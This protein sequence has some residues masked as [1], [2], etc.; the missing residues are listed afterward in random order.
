MSVVTIKLRLRDKHSASLQKQARAVNFVWN[1]CNETQRKAAQSGRQWL[2]GFDLQKLT[3]GS[4]QMLGLHAHTIQRV[5]KTY[6]EARRTRRKP[7]LRF[8]GKKS[9]G[10]VP[11]NQAHVRILGDGLLRFNGVVY[12]T[13]HWREL[14]HGAVILGGS[15]N[16]DARGRWYINLPVDLPDLPKAAGT[17]VGIDLGLKDLAVLST[18]E[19]IENPRHFRQL[20]G[21][22]GAA[23]RANKK[24][25]VR[26]LSAKIANC[27][28][29]HLHKASARIASAYGVIAVGNVSSSKLAR[30][31]LGKSVLDAGWSMFRQMLSYKAIRHGGIY[32]EADERLTTQVC[33]ACGT[34]PEGRPKGIADLGIRQWSC[35]CGAIHDRDVNAAKNI[36]RVGLHTLAEGAQI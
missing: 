14:P 2:S 22:Y 10:W 27:R 16:Q 31:R 24:R 23:Q 7:W 13:M 11:F 4:S 36:V 35:D 17:P 3:A 34:L 26:T 5:C 1:Y 9:L 29:D 21:R 18:G 33:S 28:K 6:Y 25:L 12:E 32:I 15:F 20:E 30:T 19:K 8:R